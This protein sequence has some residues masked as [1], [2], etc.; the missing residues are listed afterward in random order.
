MADR[1]RIGSESGGGSKL[2]AGVLI[3]S[4]LFLILFMGWIWSM[5]WEQLLHPGVAI[6]GST[7]T[8]SEGDA[9]AVMLLFAR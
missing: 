3:G 7:F 4:G 2:R 9:F 1:G 5:L 6:G 8:G